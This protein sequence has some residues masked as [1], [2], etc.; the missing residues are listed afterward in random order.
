MAVYPFP[1]N[2]NWSH[3]GPHTVTLTWNMQA[4]GEDFAEQIKLSA[5]SSPAA[6]DKHKSV[7]FS[8]GEITLDDLKPNTTYDM[9]IEAIKFDQSTYL[10]IGS[11][12]TPPSGK[13]VVVLAISNSERSDDVPIYTGENRST[14]TSSGSASTSVP[15]GVASAYMVMLLTWTLS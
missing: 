4:L 1:S 13:L 15:S 3:V 12:N 8:S 11:L 14:V 6:I 9:T 10:Y 2:F 7:E 5:V